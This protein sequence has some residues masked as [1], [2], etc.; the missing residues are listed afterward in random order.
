[1]SWFEIIKV[2]STKTTESTE[3]TII[4]KE[5]EMITIWDYDGFK[6]MMRAIAD[7]VTSRQYGPAGRKSYVRINENKVDYNFWLSGRHKESN[8]K[9]VYDFQLGENE[10]EMFTLISV[11]GPNLS[12]TMNTPVDDITDVAY[13]FQ[14]AWQKSTGMPV[15]RI[16][17]K[18]IPREGQRQSDINREVEAANPG[19]EMTD[20]GL[21]LTEDE[22]ERRAQGGANLTEERTIGMA[23]DLRSS[24]KR[25]KDLEVKDKRAD[26]KRKRRPLWQR[27]FRRK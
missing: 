27:L 24:R 6:A 22:Q 16:Q 21:Q 1:M 9:F 15:E 11:I 17:I 3:G 14:E 2:K 19:Y 8:I 18:D 20:R 12:L 4:D 13:Q 26:K 23:D 25:E 10:D 7:S 5:G